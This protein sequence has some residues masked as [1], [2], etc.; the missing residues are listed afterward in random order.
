[1]A[2]LSTLGRS[3][4]EVSTEIVVDGYNLSQA[5]ASDAFA[6]AVQFLE[7][8]KQQGADLG[9]IPSVDADLGTINATIGAFSPPALPA[10]PA[11]LTPAFPTAPADPV[12][13]PVG[14]L[15][16]PLPPEFTTADPV[17]ATIAAPAPF[18]DAAPTAPALTTLTFPAE[19][20]SAVPSAPSLRSLALPEVPQITLP[21]FTAIL[22]PAPLK[23][24]VSF[25]YTEAAYSSALLT[26]LNTRLLEFTAGAATGL[27]AAVEQALWDRGRSREAALLYRARENAARGFAAR[28]FSLPPGALVELI[29]QADQLAIDKAASLSREQVIEHAELEQRNFQF[30]FGQ[31]VALEGQLLQ[32]SDQVAA[33]ALDAAKYAAQILIDLFNA[34]VSLFNSKAQAY[35][36]EAQVYRERLQAE[37]ARIEIYKAQLEGQKLIG[38]LNQQDVALY[39]ERIRAVL[40]LFELYKGRLEA[41][42][43]QQEQQKLSTELYRAQVEAFAARSRAKADEFTG[44]K[45]QVEAE[46]LKIEAHKSL[47]DAYKSKIDGFKALVD[48][49]V[50]AQDS[51][52]KVNQEIPLEVFKARASSFQSL[53]Q[54]EAERLRGLIGLYEGR[55]RVYSEQVR[56]ESVRVDAEAT[57]LKSEVDVKVAEANLSL[58]VLKANVTRLTELARL[59]VASMDSGSRVAAQL[60]AA[61]LSAV[62]LSASIGA[63]ASSSK[64]TSDSTNTATS[65]SYSENHNYSHEG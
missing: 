17:L 28:G 32:H 36:V 57:I 40:A 39:S 15:S 5:F 30:A 29:T 25:G 55:T 37:I 9:S 62:N 64:S 46:A 59:L 20:D 65:T 34:E 7:D 58:E 51:E 16:L 47:A 44:Y 41:V 11:G 31:A 19:P 42:K 45:T 1:M 4:T 35:Q 26:Q 13:A 10:E 52:I 38:D 61:A 27:S 23:P 54:A 33:R 49:R 22:D 43:I 6:A 63:S 8:L 18:S 21:F 56:G 24:T 12:L 53:V 50:A 48:A 2:L 60:A 14:A 3:T